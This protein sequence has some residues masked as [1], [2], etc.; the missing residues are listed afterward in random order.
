M[1]I[2]V[3]G[4]R[5]GTDSVWSLHPAGFRIQA[6]VVALI[7]GLAA[8]AWLQAVSHPHLHAMRLPL[9]VA[10]SIAGGLVAGLPLFLAAVDIGGASRELGLAVFVLAGLALV[11]CAVAGVAMIAGERRDAP[12]AAAAVLLVAAGGAVGGLLVT[13]ASPLAWISSGL[14]E[15]GGFDDNVGAG[16]WLVVLSLAV[17]A[18]SVLALAVARAGDR[19]A[20][21]YFSTCAG[22]LSAASFTFAS[23]AAF[24]FSS[25][26]MEI[27]LSL[28]LTGSAIALTCTAIGAATLALGPTEPVA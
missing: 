16:G 1:W 25:F 19:R 26:Q 11:G 28:V 5:S 27:G 13:I 2:P 14:S 3:L 9:A 4:D 24:A 12:V 21:L 8:G 18:A 7:A 20:A 17:V 15:Y 22:A 10:T 23:G 6:I